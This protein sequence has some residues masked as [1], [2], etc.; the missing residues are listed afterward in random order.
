MLGKRKPTIDLASTAQAGRKFNQLNGNPYSENYYTLL[1]QRRKLP[2]WEAKEHLIDL[3][4]DH[5]VVVLQGETGS[6]K[7]TQIPQFLIEAGYSSKL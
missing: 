2:A 5:Q 1:G 3:L 7:T 6:G 4:K